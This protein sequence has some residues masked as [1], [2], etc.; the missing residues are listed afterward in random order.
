MQEV[1]WCLATECDLA[2]GQKQWAVRHGVS[3]Q[4]V[5]DVLQGRRNPGTAICKALKLKPVKLY[6]ANTRVLRGGPQVRER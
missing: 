3:P 2:G 1:V 6:E 4:Y 5:C